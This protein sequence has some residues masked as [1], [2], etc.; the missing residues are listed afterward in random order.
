MLTLPAVLLEQAPN[1]W[2]KVAQFQLYRLA[3][4]VTFTMLD[5]AAMLAFAL[6]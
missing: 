4:Y 1:A 3:T 2:A 6:S 5:D